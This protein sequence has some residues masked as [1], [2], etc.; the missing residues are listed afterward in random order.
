MRSALAKE[1]ASDDDAAEAAVV[2]V[3]VVEV[4]VAASVVVIIIVA[5]SDC[6][7]CNISTAVESSENFCSC[8]TVEFSICSGVD[9]R[10]CFC[11]FC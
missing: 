5:D 8:L 2:V 10:G 1:I 4:P 9:K 3:A 6:S 7:E 11:C